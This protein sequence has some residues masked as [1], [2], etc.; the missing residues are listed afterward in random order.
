[1]LSGINIKEKLRQIDEHW[2]PAIIGEI[3]DY[4]IKVAKIKGEFVW[5]KHDDTDELFLVIEGNMKIALGDGEVTLGKGDL[6]IV[7]KGIEHKPVAEKECHIVLFEPAG[8]VNT[9][10]AE[11]ELTKRNLSKI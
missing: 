6:Y 11:S 1:M 5:H 10:N 2:S 7:K 9:G 8:T 4:H 3:N